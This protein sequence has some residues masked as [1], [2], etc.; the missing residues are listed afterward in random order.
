[1][2]F[3]VENHICKCFFH[4]TSLPPPDLSEHHL[5]INHRHHSYRHR[6]QSDYKAMQKQEANLLISYKLFSILSFFYHQLIPGHLFFRCDICAVIIERWLWRTGRAEVVN[7]D[8]L[9]LSLAWMDVVLLMALEYMACMSFR[10]VWHEEAW[11]QSREKVS[12][13]EICFLFVAKI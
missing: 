3:Q 7:A 13:Y 1:M 11:R 8:T 5:H 12:S 4:E 10:R 6:D 2:H 9:V